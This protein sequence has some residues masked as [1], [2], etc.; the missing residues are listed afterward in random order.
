MSSASYWLTLD[1]IGDRV[2]VVAGVY[3][4]GSLKAARLA[5]MAKAGGAAC[6]LVFLPQSMTMG[7]AA[8]LSPK[9]MPAFAAE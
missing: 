3:T 5:G 9:A 1:E 7:A 2:P 4:G 6:L 8:G